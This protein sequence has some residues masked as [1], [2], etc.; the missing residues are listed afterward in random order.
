MLFFYFPHLFVV[1]VMLDARAVC[2]VYQAS[3]AVE[4]SILY[5]NLFLIWDGIKDLN[6]I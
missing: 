4:A 1:A 6:F 3:V 2:F 5:D